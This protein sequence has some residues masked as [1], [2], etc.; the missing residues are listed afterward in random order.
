[1]EMKGYKGC[2]RHTAENTKLRA[3]M[4]TQEHSGAENMSGRVTK[5]WLHHLADT[6]SGKL[7]SLTSSFIK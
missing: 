4:Q 7:L 1:M 3:Q 5:T 6:N 2:S